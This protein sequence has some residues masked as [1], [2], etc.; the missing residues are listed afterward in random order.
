LN[1]VPA[2]SSCTPTSNVQ[3]CSSRERWSAVCLR[4]S[5]RRLLSGS[6]RTPERSWSEPQ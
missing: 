5:G 3:R 1:P 4:T 2:S 6:T